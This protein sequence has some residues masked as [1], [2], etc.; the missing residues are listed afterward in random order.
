V[1]LGLSAD[2]SIQRATI[3]LAMSRSWDTLGYQKYR[4]DSIVEEEDNTPQWT[5]A[6]WAK[7]RE[8]W[9]R[10]PG[11]FGQPAHLGPD[12]NHALV[13]LDRERIGREA[14]PTGAIIDSQSVKTTEAG[15][16]DQHDRCQESEYLSSELIDVPSG[17]LPSPRWKLA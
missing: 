4:Y 7:S 8:E 5:R 10:S 16:D 17:P 12:I 13:M 14:S 6:R 2:I 15:R 9:R 1:A 11:H 3:L